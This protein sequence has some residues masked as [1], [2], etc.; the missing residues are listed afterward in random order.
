[1]RGVDSNGVLLGAW[2]MARCALWR[3]A[4]SLRLL[5]GKSIFAIPMCP[6][7]YAMCPTP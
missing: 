1:M 4:R 2:R 5:Y 6:K 3:M 7:P